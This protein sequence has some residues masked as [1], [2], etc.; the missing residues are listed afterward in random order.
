M[1][2]RDI[3]N[4]IFNKPGESLQ[5]EHLPDPVICAPNYGEGELLLDY[6]TAYPFTI[7]LQNKHTPAFLQI[8]KV[9]IG[10]SN[11]YLFIAS[12]S[13]TRQIDST[14]QR[15]G[16]TLVLTV[17][18]QPNGASYAKLCAIDG[19]GL[20]LATLKSTL[21]ASADWAGTIIADN[22]QTTYQLQGTKPAQLQP[23]QIST[24]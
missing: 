9:K 1:L 21:H 3:L 16:L 7:T 20:T 18:P 10:I 12:L 17:N 15:D 22:A 4:L 14:W 23:N 11:G 6:S 2:R 5:P 24:V 13:G 8:G 19:D